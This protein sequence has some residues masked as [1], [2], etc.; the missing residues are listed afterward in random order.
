MAHGPFLSPSSRA[1]PLP[2]SVPKTTPPAKASPLKAAR[3]APLPPDPLPSPSPGPAG[4]FADGQRTP[5]PGPAAG[6]P[7]LAKVAPQM[8]FSCFFCDFVCPICGVVYSFAGTKVEKLRTF[9]RK[10]VY[11][12]KLYNTF[13]S[14]QKHILHEINIPLQGYSGGLILALCWLVRLCMAVGLVRWGPGASFWRLVL[15]RRYDTRSVS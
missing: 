5:P 11:T 14:Q 10:K 1:L 9:N 12:T 8:C 7:A 3:T 6:G 4:S 15:A 13:R 2:H